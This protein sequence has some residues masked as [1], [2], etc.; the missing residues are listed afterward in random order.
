[1]RHDASLIASFVVAR[2][3]VAVVALSRRTGTCRLLFGQLILGGGFAL[4]PEDALWRSRPVALLVFCQRF[5]ILQSGGFQL[6][7][8]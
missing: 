3:S 5:D 8:K 4:L 1:M 2:S 7:F 6:I